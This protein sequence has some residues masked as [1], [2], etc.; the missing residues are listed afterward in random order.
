MAKPLTAPK[1]GILVAELAKQKDLDLPPLQRPTRTEAGLP[2]KGATIAYGYGG[3]PVEVMSAGR[4]LGWIY[5]AW[6]DDDGVTPN[7]GQ[8][9]KNQLLPPPPP[10]PIVNVP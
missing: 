4:G 6:L 3:F 1:R 5:V 7:L 10:P 2:A 8:V 9:H